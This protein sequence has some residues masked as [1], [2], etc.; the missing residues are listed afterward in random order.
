MVDKLK[1]YADVINRL[2]EEAVACSPEAWAR[3][4]LF[5]QCDGQRLTYQLKSEASTDRASI[6]EPLR[7]LVDELYT[8]MHANREAWTSAEL[9]WIWHGDDDVSVNLKFDYSSSDGDGQ[10]TH[11]H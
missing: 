11:A 9:S 3:G 8:R 1:Q 6:S 2:T 7:E 10:T 4:T 5:M